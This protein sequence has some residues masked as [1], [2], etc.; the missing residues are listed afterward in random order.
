[1]IPLN[2]LL[3]HALLDLTRASESAGAKEIVLWSNL[4][5]VVGDDGVDRHALPSL[6]RLSKRVVNT[7]VE[8]MARHEWASVDGG[9]VRLAEVARRARWGYSYGAAPAPYRA[10]VSVNV[11]P[12]TYA[13]FAETTTVT[14]PVRPDFRN[15]IRWMP[16]LWPASLVC[17]TRFVPNVAMSS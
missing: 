6:V 7:M 11:S 13:L 1:M 17:S 2:V 15:V 10:G 5:R 14:C 9:V 3:S 16:E 4:L 12:R 8:G